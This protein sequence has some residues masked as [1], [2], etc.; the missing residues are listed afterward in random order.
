MSS[1]RTVNTSRKGDRAVKLVQSIL[2]HNSQQNKYRGNKRID[3]KVESTAKNLEAAG[4][5][6]VNTLDDSDFHN[7]GFA[8]LGKFCRLDTQ[9]MKQI[10]RKFNYR[11]PTPIQIRAIPMMLSDNRPDILIQS[12][13]GSGK[14][15][16]YLIPIIDFILQ[17]KKF[18]R[19]MGAVAFCI[20]PT[21]E[22]ALQIYSVASKLVTKLMRKL[23]V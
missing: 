19:S 23:R 14:T 11:D 18:E 21:R 20:A 6:N 9:L 7:S 8:Q 15:L 2:D 17:S 16:T 22:L 5:S 12:A 13:T 3:S 4:S 1:S 10:V